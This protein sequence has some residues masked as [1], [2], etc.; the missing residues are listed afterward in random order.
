MSLEPTAVDGN[1]AVTAETTLG[2]VKTTRSPARVNQ[3]C[4]PPEKIQVGSNL[5][6][7][8]DLQ[9]CKLFNQV[10]AQ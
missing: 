5:F 4:P 1:V 2:R 3:F 7:T 10:G 8:A 6:D 9:I